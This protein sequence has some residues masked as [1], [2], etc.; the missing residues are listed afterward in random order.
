MDTPGCLSWI[1]Q[2]IA[3]PRTWVPLERPYV[4]K[5]TRNAAIDQLRGHIEVPAGT[6]ETR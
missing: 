1:P 2:P 4:S 6:Q 5:A 3:I